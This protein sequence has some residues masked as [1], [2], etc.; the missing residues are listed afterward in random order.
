MVFGDGGAGD[1]DTLYIAAGPSGTSIFGAISDNTD[2]PHPTSHWSGH[3][4]P[5]RYIR[6]RPQLFSSWQLLQKISEG[7]F[8]S[9]ASASISASP[10]AKSQLAEFAA[11]IEVAAKQRSWFSS[12]SPLSV[13]GSPDSAA[14]ALA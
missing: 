2:V 7:C 3:P 10:A 12:A 14:A 9:H 13:A 8:H 11:R 6:E 5:Q 4:L 1:R